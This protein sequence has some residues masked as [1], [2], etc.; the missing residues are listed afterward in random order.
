MSRTAEIATTGKCRYCK[1]IFDIDPR[2]P[3]K[4]FCK[5]G[6]RKLFWR[7][8]QHSVTK[9]AERMQRENKKLIASEL[10]AAR[11]ELKL[12]AAEN[13]AILVNLSVGCDAQMVMIDTLMKLLNGL[14]EKVAVF[15]TCGAAAGPTELFGKIEAVEAAQ[16][17]RADIVRSMVDALTLLLRSVELRVRALE[18][19]GG[20]GAAA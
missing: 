4:E 11:R 17:E 20:A 18:A 10:K 13:R 19:R 5:E 6:H 16:T 1:A 2:H 12:D 7:Y 9:L 8:G 3:N 14:E 15:E